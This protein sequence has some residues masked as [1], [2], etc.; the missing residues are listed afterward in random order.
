LLPGDHPEAEESRRRS[1]VNRKVC[2]GALHSS[3]ASGGSLTL[4]T[5]FSLPSA[6]ASR[7]ESQTRVRGNIGLASGPA[8]E[9]GTRESEIGSAHAAPNRTDVSAAGATPW[10]VFGGKPVIPE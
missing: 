3:L 10:N 1:N 5:A 8:S 9:A 4:L 2:E 7:S 6:N